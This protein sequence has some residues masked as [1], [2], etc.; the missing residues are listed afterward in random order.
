MLNTSPK[1]MAHNTAYAA[2]RKLIVSSYSKMLCFTCSTSSRSRSRRMRCHIR[3]TYQTVNVSRQAPVVADYLMPGE[4]LR[5]TL[6][7]SRDGGSSLSIESIEFFV[8]FGDGSQSRLYGD[9]GSTVVIKKT[10][11]SIFPNVGGG[12]VSG[13]SIAAK[14]IS[15]NIRAIAAEP[16]M[17]DDAYRSLQAGRIIPSENP[18]T[19]ADGLL[20][21]LC[22][23]TFSIIQKNVE[24]IVTVRE[25]AILE[26]MKFIWE[27][28]KIIIEPSAAVPVGLLW[29]RKIELSGLRVGVILSGGNV[30]LE[31]LL[32]QPRRGG[33]NVN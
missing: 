26:S 7:I 11:G 12:L 17:A 16:E 6:S 4:R 8:G 32:W 24:Q 9:G 21:S 2:T 13:T 15:P 18:K 20:T 1:E 28:A 19:I 23:L 22:D 25:K 31:K 27:R 3:I 14:G 33:A 30:D 10:D 29:E 5:Y